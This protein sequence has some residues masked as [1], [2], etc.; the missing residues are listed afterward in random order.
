MAGNSFS[1][2]KTVVPTIVL[3]D[4]D[5]DGGGDADD[6]GGDAD[7]DDNGDDDDGDDDDISDGVSRVITLINN[8]YKY[9]DIKRT[10]KKTPRACVLITNTCG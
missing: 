3:D 10:N 1:E 6:G 2:G 7:G 4:D 8:K 5:D 9:Y